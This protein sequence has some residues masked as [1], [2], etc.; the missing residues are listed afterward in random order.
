MPE[1]TQVITAPGNVVDTDGGDTGHT[2][3]WYE[4]HRITP[5]EQAT[6]KWA[7]ERTQDIESSKVLK[8][9]LGLEYD[10][11][12]SQIDALIPEARN[13]GCAMACASKFC[14]RSDVIATNQQAFL[15]NVD[16]AFQLLVMRIEPRSKP[17]R[18]DSPMG[19]LNA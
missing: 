3:D 16:L 4:A 13:D 18:R 14:T 12:R 7:E 19:S 17:T 6:S 11:Y 15:H 2:Q 5:A 8:N 1:E 10:A 9:T